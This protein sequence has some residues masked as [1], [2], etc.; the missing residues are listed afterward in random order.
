MKKKYF[1][2]LALVILIVFLLIVFMLYYNN[3]EN[4]NSSDLSIIKDSDKIKKSTDNIIKDIRYFSKDDK[5]NS[6][7][8][9]SDFGE[10]SLDNPDLIFMTNVVA[11]INLKNSSNVVITS[12]FA[13]F[14]NKSYET[15]FY[16][17]VKILRDD[18]KIRS[19]KLEFSLEKDLILISNNVVLEKPGFNLKADRVEIDLIT[20]NSKIFMNDSTKKVIAIGKNE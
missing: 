1:F 18:E 2:Q 4:N 20:K 3:N 13:N 9:V 6:Y 8:I 12:K 10:I 16:E 15:T 7:E 19:Q 5:G 11:T 14:N 17:N